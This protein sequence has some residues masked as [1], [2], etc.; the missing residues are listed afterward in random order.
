M[1]G[2][3]A[4]ERPSARTNTGGARVTGVTADIHV[5]E[6]YRNGDFSGAARY[7]RTAAGNAT[8]GTAHRLADMASSIDRFSREYQRVRAAGDDTLRVARS[9]ESAIALDQDISGGSA[10]AAQLRPLLVTATVAA[11]VSAWNAG[12]FTESCQ[13]IR[14]AS[15]L[16][17]RNTTVRD[18]VRRCEQR[19]STVLQD[20]VAS[21]RSNV[22]Q[23]QE[24]YRAVLTLVPASSPS[25]RTAAARLS[26]L[27]HAR[28]VDEDE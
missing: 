23:A 15:E 25:Y 10:Y 28:P 2:A 22:T 8:G 19:A 27:G 12:Q 6:L 26:A 16:D 14:R 11:A 5:L 4:F 3:D 17:S 9:I 21:E 1:L 20:A 13:K 18:Y 24:L 7:A